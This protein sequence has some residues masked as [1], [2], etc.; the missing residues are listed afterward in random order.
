MSPPPQSFLG[1]H[2]CALCL[3]PAPYIVQRA[4][5]E[6]LRLEQLEQVLGDSRSRVFLEDP[7]IPVAGHVILEA[8]ELHAPVGW[9]VFDGERSEIGETAVR[10]DG[11]ELRGL[12]DDLLI[13]PGVLEGLEYGDIDCLGAY[14]RDGPA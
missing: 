10:A 1:E 3:E 9:G 6:H 2:H 11:G 13:G 7:H 12:G 5:L 8:L 14:E 4:D